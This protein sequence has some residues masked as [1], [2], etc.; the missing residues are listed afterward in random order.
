MQRANRWITVVLALVAISTATAAQRQSALSASQ[1][2]KEELSPAP[3]P[4]EAIQANEPAVAF[5]FE[6]VD[7]P[8][9]G[10]H[11]N[12][13][14][15]NDHSRVVGT[16]TALSSNTEGYVL[17]GS[18][19]KK[20]VYTSAGVN[21][22]SAWG[23][24]KAGVVVGFYSSDGGST[25]HGFML[26]GKN[27]STLDY[28]GATLTAAYAINAS[29]VIV[30][31]YSTTSQ[32]IPHGFMLSGGVYTPI[33]FPSATNTTAYAINGSGVIVGTYQLPDGSV[34]GFTFQGGSYTSVDYPGGLET[35]LNSVNDSGQIVGTYVDAAD[36]GHGLLL[37][38]GIFT[39]FDAPFAGV[40]LTS[41]GGI[42]NK[43]QIA[44]RYVDNA[45]FRWGFVATFQ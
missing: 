27:Y 40:T 10:A 23:I 7:F 3:A 28:P 36:L 1:L 4:T 16:Y 38:D 37:K 24:N 30:G 22:T 45:G 8:A 25:G 35:I 32:F 2:L 14:Q 18:S 33:D 21:V 19:F 34:H 20:I 44:G 15:I 26:K 12:A 17:Q 29:G 9:V 41:P 5:T 11:Q 43:N 13:H 6:V 42:N 31:A 39:S